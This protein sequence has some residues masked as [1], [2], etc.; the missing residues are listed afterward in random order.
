MHMLAI[1]QMPIILPWDAHV[2]VG[3]HSGCMQCCVLS[4]KDVVCMMHMS[5]VIPCI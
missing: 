4:I 2:H 1:N 3:I 5:T